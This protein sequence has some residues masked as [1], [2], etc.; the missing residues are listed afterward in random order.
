MNSKKLSTSKPVRSG[1]KKA[2]AKAVKSQN[3]KEIFANHWL[4][5]VSIECEPPQINIA[6][7]EREL[8]WEVHAQRATSA[9]GGIEGV[10]VV[11]RAHVLWKSQPYVLAEIRYAGSV[12][13]QHQS[14]GFEDLVADLYGPARDAMAHVLALAGQKPPLPERIEDINT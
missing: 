10:V 6:A 2:L 14:V 13:K 1:T 8:Q 4:V 3:N 5:D 9:T 12:N 7:G 11:I